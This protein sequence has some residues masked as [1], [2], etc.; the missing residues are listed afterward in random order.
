VGLSTGDVIADSI[1]V[2][3]QVRDVVAGATIATYAP[4]D[5]GRTLRVAVDSILRLIDHPA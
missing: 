4:N 1:R 5:E 3:T 2:N